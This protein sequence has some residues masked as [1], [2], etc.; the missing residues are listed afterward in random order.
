V[1]IQLIVIPIFV[2][3]LSLVLGIHFAYPQILKR[4][5]QKSTVFLPDDSG[6]KSYSHSDLPPVSILI[7]VYNEELSIEPRINNIF[8][9]IY[10][11]DKL[12]IIIIESGSSDR[13]RS[14]IESTFKN[15][16]TLITEQERRGKAHAINLGLQ[17]CKGEIIIVT[18]GTTLYNNETILEIV[19]SF[20]DN[21]IG[22]VSAFYEVPNSDESHVSASERKFWSYKDNVRLL[23]SNVASTSWLSGEACA[24]RCKII[25]KVHE[26]TL[27]DDS[28]IALQLISKGYRVIVNQDARFIERSPTQFSDYVK[29]KSRRALGG[30]TETLRFKSLLFNRDY[31][32]FGT[33]IFPYRFFVCL[34]SPILSSLLIGL[35]VPAVIELV[36]LTGFFFAVLLGIG[37]VS[38]FIP[39]KGL[40]LT[41]FYAQLITTIAL[42]WWAFGKRDVRWTRSKTR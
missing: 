41:F 28:N 11:K 27:A 38:I 20:K 31:G 25:D 8:E 24:F 42:F 40:L 37:L 32:Y 14:I 34:L 21:K 23:E 2:I 36:S 26:D 13:T 5:S 17:S 6:K 30:L 22:A 4:L 35:T 7:P 1:N 33:I 3:I 12:E 10:P 18:D 19:S 16:V 39:F 15:D 9:C 29:I